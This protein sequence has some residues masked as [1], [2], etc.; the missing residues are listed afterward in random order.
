MGFDLWWLAYPA[1]GAVAGFLAGLIGI[2]GGGMMVPILTSVFLAQGMPL[3]HVVHLSLGTAMAVMVITA[4]SSFRTH[5]R[6]GSVRWDIWRMMT[7]GILIGAFGTTFLAAKVPSQPLAFFFACFMGLMAVQMMINIKPSPSRDLPGPLGVGAVGMG[8]G[9]IS[10]LV[11]IGGAAMSV[12]FMMWCNVKIQHAIGTSAAI[13]WPVAIAGALGY[14]INGWGTPGLPPLSVGF[15][16]LP[17]LVGV[18][19]VGVITAPIGARLAHRMPVERLKK[20]LAVFFM[21][22]SLKMLHSVFF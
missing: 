9:S 5:H 20:V 1:L 3:T 16:Y 6:L 15:V 17:A 14:V 8:I 10:S 18:A 11:A 7:P 21:L 13:G 4:V 22:L 12:P 2:G 19:V